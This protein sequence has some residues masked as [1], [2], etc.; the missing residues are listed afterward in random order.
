MGFKETGCEGMD[1]IHLAEGRIKWR[2]TERNLLVNYRPCPT[3]V[4][5][6]REVVVGGDGLE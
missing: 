4:K 6:K 3:E 5:D 1:I 2:R